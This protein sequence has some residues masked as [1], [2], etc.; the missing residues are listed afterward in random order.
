MSAIITDVGVM[1]ND[2]ELTSVWMSPVKLAQDTIERTS[3]LSVES[4]RSWWNGGPL[5]LLEN[6]SPWLRNY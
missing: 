6:A 4:I 2:L 5:T 3:L 1:L